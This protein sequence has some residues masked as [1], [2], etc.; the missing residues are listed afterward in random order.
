[1]VEGV[2]PKEPDNS[3]IFAG[4]YKQGVQIF[5]ESLQRYHEIPKDTQ[6]PM[7]SK[8]KSLFKQA[9]DDALKAMHD[10]S[11]P[12]FG[13]GIKSKEKKLEQDY[14]AFLQNED[15]DHLEAVDKDLQ[16]ITNTINHAS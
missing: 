2:N 4:E 11:V 6:D 13:E 5:K 8:Q 10:S 9:A 12:G 3:K 15:A 7:Q 14:K 1:M 16:D